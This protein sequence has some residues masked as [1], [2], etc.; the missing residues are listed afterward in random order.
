MAAESTKSSGSADAYIGSFISLISKAQ[1]RYQG[2]LFHLNPQESTIGLRN[3]KSFGTEGR[4][5]DGQHVLPSDKIYEYIFFRGSDIKDLRVI[6]SPSVHSTPVVPDD[7]AIIQPHYPRSTSAS[8]SFPCDSAITATNISSHAQLGL[9][10]STFQGN[11]TLNQPVGSLGSWG[12]FPHPPTVNDNGIA[13]PTCWPGQGGASGGVSHLQQHSFLQP[14]QGLSVVSPPMIQQ[15]QNLTMNASLPCD[16]SNSAEFSRPL[17][18]AVCS[19]S[20]NSSVPIKPSTTL[21]SNLSSILMP[22][23]GSNVFPTVALGSSSPLA[24]PLMAF[25]LDVNPVVTP[26]TNKPKSVF[27]LALPNQTISQSTPSIVGSFTPDPCEASIPSLLTPDQ[28][29]QPGPMGHSSS[30]LQIAQKDIEVVQASTAKLLSSDSKNAKDP[31]QSLPSPTAKKLNGAVFRSHHSNKRH[32]RENKL[33]GTDAHTRCGEK[34]HARGKANWLNGAALHNHHSYRGYAR[35]RAK[36]PNKPAVHTHRSDGGHGR[37]RG[38]QVSPTIIKFTEDFDFDA[39]NAKFNKEEIW[40]HL[41]KSNKNRMEDEEG[42]EN[43]NSANDAGEEDEDG[44]PNCDVKNV[45][46]KD[47]FFDSL[48]CLTLDGGSGRGRG[49]GRAKFSKQKKIDIET[50]GEVP[51]HQRGRPGWVGQSRGSHRG[52]GYHYVGRGCGQTVWSRVT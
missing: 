7:P 32:G 44:L 24:S 43:D 18:P 15:M 39:M 28:L 34:D 52:R 14:P 31:V 37:G 19:S 38:T 42:N 4:R 45:Y 30:H 9:P 50:F 29:L 27:D 22:N 20:P 26:V 10:N 21:P 48:S 23:K 49:R 13:M 47:D 2:F 1:I 51:R 33:S 8:S 35:G 41:R 12:S 5:K 46:V 36:G 6:S 11:L 3:V 40:G 17:L 25:S 16:A